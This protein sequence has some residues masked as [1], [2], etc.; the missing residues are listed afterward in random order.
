MPIDL[1]ITL[2]FILW[3]ILRFTL[4][5]GPYEMDPCGQGTFFPHLILYSVFAYAQVAL[6]IIGATWAYGYGAKD[7]AGILLFA[8]ILALLFAGVLAFSFEAYMAVRYKPPT[9]CAKSNYSIGRYA[10]VLSLG[11]SSTALLIFGAVW[12]AV[13]AGK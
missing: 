7:A 3:L 1:A 5:A 2:P 8:A 9:C 11:I 10:L 4:A 13:E 12:A 6:G